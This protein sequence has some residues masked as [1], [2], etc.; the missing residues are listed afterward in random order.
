MWFLKEL[1]NHSSW[2]HRKP[3]PYSQERKSQV[4]NVSQ[5]ENTPSLQTA[6]LKSNMQPKKKCHRFKCKASC[7][8]QS[9]YRSILRAFHFSKTMS[10]KMKSL[11]RWRRK[12]TKIKFV[13]HGILHTNE[14]TNYIWY[15]S[16]G[17]YVDWLASL[18]TPL[19]WKQHIHRHTICCHIT[20]VYNDIFAILTCNFSKE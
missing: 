20:D 16:A 6:S 15:I 3:I 5:I 12:M 13:V 17:G 19:H 1:L 9:A 18:H 4:S 10:P 11:K 8:S 2:T 14:C 7:F